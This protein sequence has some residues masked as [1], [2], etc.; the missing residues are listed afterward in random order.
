[1]PAA[2]L[3]R[4]QVLA[5]LDGLDRSIPW[6]HHFDLGGVETITEAEDPKFYRKALGAKLFCDLALTYREAFA[7]G[8]PLSESRILDVACAEG[9]MSVAFGLAGAREVV[10][11]E[12][13]R[14]AVERARFAAR[15]LGAD[16]VRF[17][18]GDVRAMAGQLDGRFDFA[19]VLGILHHLG[20]DDFFP[21]LKSLG[22]L[23]D[24]VMLY[25]HLSTPDSIRDYRLEGPVE[26]RPGF[27]GYLSREHEDDATPEERERQV[28][29]SL[30]NT[31]SFRPTDETLVRALKKAGFGLIAKMYEPHAFGDHRNR[32]FRVIYVAKRKALHGA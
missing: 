10:G 5:E 18:Q 2:G 9:A 14:L 22:R 21:F 24:A 19:L 26:P 23:T 7:E 28:R 17:V 3:T 8:K 13:R 12:G 32:N 20:P 16:T 15:A 31:F 1:M 27:V 11:V 6:T 29:A 25:T 4:E 30:D